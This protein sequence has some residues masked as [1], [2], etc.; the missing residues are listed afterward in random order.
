MKRISG[1]LIGVTLIV[2]VLTLLGWWL[3]IEVFKRP[4]A[5][6]DIMNPV[7]ALSIFTASVSFFLTYKINAGKKWFLFA[8]VLAVFVLSVG[9][10]KVLAI[11]GIDVQINYWLFRDKVLAD[12]S[13]PAH[14]DPFSLINS[15]YGFLITGASLLLAQRK[16]RWTG[17]AINYMALSGFIIGTFVFIGFVYRVDEFYGILPY[18]SVAP[19]TGVCFMC[20]SLGMLFQNSDLG[21]L[22]VIGSRD[23]GGQIARPLIPIGIGVP[24]VFGYIGLILASRWHLSLAFG[25]AVLSTSIVVVFLV[26][27]WFLARTLNDSDAERKQAEARLAQQAQLFNIMPDAVVYGNKDLSIKHMNPAARKIFEVEENAGRPLVL[28]DLF[29]VEMSAEARE[30]VRKDLWGDKGSW[31]GESILTTRSGKKIQV[32]NLLQSISN[33]QGEKVAWF[34]VYTDI[35]FLRLNEELKTANDYLEQLAFISAHDIKSPIL[36]LQGLVDV[37]SR[38]K[39]ISDED[40]KVLEMQKTVIRQMQQTNNALNDILKLRKNLRI[41]DAKGQEKLPLDKILD[42][43]RGLLETGALQNASLLVNVDEVSTT[44]LPTVYFQ[45]L[46][47][48]LISNSLKYQDPARPLVIHFSGKKKDQHTIQF[49]VEDNGLGFDLAHNKHRIFG[50]FKRFHNHVE[51]TGIGLHIVKSIVEAFDGTIEVDS[52]PGKGTRFEM[53]FKTGSLS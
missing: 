6:N 23:L 3:D 14:S 8:R 10:L 51:G 22:A 49:I 47:Y 48:N 15:A 36:S 38:S 41:K 46:F 19:A 31:R 12:K 20:F 4:F 13:T 18:M 11:A 21:I 28:D 33:E 25:A 34:G 26:V 17:I 29:T 24:L 52:Q 9:L 30:A 42:N 1:Y 7:T 53:T 44:L 50:I 43:I 45:S 5:N 39:N 40:M 2:S 37:L 27:L 35:T 32:M 16:P